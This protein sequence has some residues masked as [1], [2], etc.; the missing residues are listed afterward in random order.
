MN[1]DYG[2]GAHEKANKKAGEFKEHAA[3]CTTKRDKFHLR[4]VE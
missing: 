2:D 1:F 4:E 3:D